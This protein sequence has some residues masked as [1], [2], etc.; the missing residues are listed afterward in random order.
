MEIPIFLQSDLQQLN[1]FIAFPLLL[2]G[3]L[4][5]LLVAIGLVKLEHVIGG[6]PILLLHRKLEL[7]LV[8]HLGN[9]GGGVGCIGF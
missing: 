7:E 9:L 4:Q 3:V 5:N 6:F 8:I 1:L 2:P